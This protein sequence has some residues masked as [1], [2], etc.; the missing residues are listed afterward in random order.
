LEAVY[1][2]WMNRPRLDAT[3]LFE[4]A[5]PNEWTVIDLRPLRPK[6]EPALRRILFGL[7]AVAVDIPEVVHPST[8]VE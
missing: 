2:A 3:P 5:L 4:A 8:L 6:A 7:D 1:Q